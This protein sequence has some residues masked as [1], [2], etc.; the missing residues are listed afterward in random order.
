ME[1]EERPWGRYEVLEEADKYKVKRI[2]VKP[3]ARLS[4]QSHKYRD[5]LWVVV[6][7]PAGIVLG[8]N[9]FILEEGKNVYIPREE[10]HRLFN[11]GKETIKVIEVQYGTYLGE[12]DIIRYEDDYKRM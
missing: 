12:D 8:D 6:K 11:T 3:G 10:K 9:E 1:K 5:E 2:E 4:L 7:G